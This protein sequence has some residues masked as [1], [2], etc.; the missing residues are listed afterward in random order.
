MRKP[1]PTESLKGA[2]L[3]EMLWT[4]GVGDRDE[5]EITNVLQVLRGA[6]SSWRGGN[7]KTNFKS[8][9]VGSL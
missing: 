1:K 7:K 9:T 5:D 3:N 4:S 6:E 2:G 8:S